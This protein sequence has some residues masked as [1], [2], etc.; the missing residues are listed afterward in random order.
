MIKDDNKKFIYYWVLFLIVFFFSWWSNPSLEGRIYPDTWDYIHLAEDLS[1]S[2]NTL[3]PFLYPLII[4]LAKFISLDNWSTIVVLIQILFHSISI[5]LIFILFQ[6]NKFPIVLNF[7]FAL[8]IGINPNLIYWSS[9]IVPTQLFGCFILINLFLYLNYLDEY[10]NTKNVW[11]K[12]FF[13]FGLFSAFTVTLRSMY[14]FGIVPFLIS[15][16]FLGRWKKIG[17]MPIIS[18]I[19]LHLSVNTIWFGYKNSLKQDFLYGKKGFHPI[20]NTL[21]TGGANINMAAIRGGLVDSGE[22]TYLYKVLEQK[23]LLN[24]A[25][26]CTS[27]DYTAEFDTLY[28]K[29]TFQEKCDREFSEKV[30]NTH[31][32]KIILIQLSNWHEFFTKRM[33]NP[34]FYGMPSIIKYIYVGSYNNLYRPIMPILL[35][36]F[37]FLLVTKK[38]YGP[39]ALISCLLVLFFSLGIAI[40]SLHP[41]L[42]IYYRTA[43]EY[44]L[45]ICVFLPVIY[46][47]DLLSRNRMT[48]WQNLR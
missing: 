5:L 19:I 33:H 35:L 46:I 15:I 44:V 10:K 13:I 18:L 39:L 1:H 22:G 16:F 21:K 43:I 36:M 34:N 7:I 24:L 38:I 48:K 32:M 3:R 26:S 40:S 6:K 25:R 2:D 37:I 23:G 28:K 29:L 17:I 12:Y 11:N 27:G 42:F 47:Y 41:G 8:A 9:A 31:A 4:R 14:L 20:K 45:F 30:W